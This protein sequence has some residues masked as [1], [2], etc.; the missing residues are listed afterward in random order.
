MRHRDRALSNYAIHLCLTFS[1][2]KASQKLG[3]TF[4][5]V[6]PTFVNSTDPWRVIQNL[7]WVGKHWSNLILKGGLKNSLDETSHTKGVVDNVATDV[8][9]GSLK[10]KNKQ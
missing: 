10:V 1:S 2:Q 7:G 4:Y 6:H 8:K 9:K 3:I 5:A